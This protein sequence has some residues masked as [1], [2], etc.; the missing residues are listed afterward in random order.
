MFSVSV[1]LYLYFSEETIQT[2]LGPYKPYLWT[3]YILNKISCFDQFLIASRSENAEGMG[4]TEFLRGYYFVLIC[5][6]IH[7]FYLPNLAYFLYH[8]KTLNICTHKSLK[9]L[10]I[11]YRVYI[12]GYIFPLQLSAGV[13][14]VK[15]ILYSFRGERSQINSYLW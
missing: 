12:F 4:L 13:L 3:V 11:S 8:W 6:I 10:S 5:N 1:A 9:Y 2:Y 14:E 7:R 15:S